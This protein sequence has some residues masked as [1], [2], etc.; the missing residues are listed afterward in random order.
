MTSTYVEPVLVEIKVWMARRDVTQV[1]LAKRLGVA[2][3]WVSKRLNGVVALTVEDM[4]RIAVALNVPPWEFMR[5]APQVS[6]NSSSAT[7]LMQYRYTSA[8]MGKVRAAS[9]RTL[10]PAA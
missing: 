8:L 9:A 6:S 5:P 4:A 2:Q 3:S 1:E 10:K 7:E